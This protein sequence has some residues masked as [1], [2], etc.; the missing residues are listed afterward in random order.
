MFLCGEAFSLL[1]RILK[2]SLCDKHHKLN[3]IQSLDKGM[4]QS[5]LT[6]RKK[7]AFQAVSVDFE[8]KQ[9]LS[10][11][12]MNQK[13]LLRRFKMKFKRKLMKKTRQTLK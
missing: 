8:V 3:Y 9:I 4:V 6:L 7:P 12:Y 11:C 13:R 5:G 2:K 10:Y 1:D